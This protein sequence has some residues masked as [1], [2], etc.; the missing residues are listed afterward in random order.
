MSVPL[1]A[2]TAPSLWRPA[3]A[4]STAKV[5]TPVEHVF[6]TWCNSVF[7][8]KKVRKNE[9]MAVVPDAGSPR[10]E[11]RAASGAKRLRSS[12]KSPL[13]CPAVFDRVK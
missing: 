9:A 3:T 11:T 4:Q 5:P 8:A 7:R 2:K 13:S 10:P 6:E 12:S 1:I